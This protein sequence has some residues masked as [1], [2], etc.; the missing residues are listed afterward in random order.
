MRV[1]RIEH[2][3]TG[4]GIYN[5]DMDRCGL[6]ADEMNL[7][8][9]LRLYRFNSS[10]SRPT[11]VTDRLFG[12][13]YDEGERCGFKTPAQLDSWFGRDFVWEAAAAGFLTSVYEVDERWVRHGGKQVV[14]RLPHARLTGRYRTFNELEELP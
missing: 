8:L 1:Y 10:V 6:T 7:W 4:A 12:I 3:R 2:V 11:P 13:S 9:G 14:F 5:A